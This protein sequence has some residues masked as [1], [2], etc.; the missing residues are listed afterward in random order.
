[1]RSGEKLIGKLKFG[2]TRLGEM[3]FQGNVDRGNEIWGNF[4]QENEIS[5]VM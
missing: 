2:E 4:T 5:K 3:R 1:L